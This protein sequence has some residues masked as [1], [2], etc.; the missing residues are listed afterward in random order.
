M[1]YMISEVAKLL[2]YLHTHC[3][4]MKRKRSLS[5]SAMRMEKDYMMNPMLLG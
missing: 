3:D 1:Y 4:T 2:G 5:R